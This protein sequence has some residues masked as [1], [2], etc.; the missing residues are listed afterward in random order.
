MSTESAR[1]P[2]R[3]AFLGPRM[4]S[5]ARNRGCPAPP[6]Q[7]EASAVPRAP[8]AARAK[9]GVSD[10]RVELED[11]LAE[12]REVRASAVPGLPA[13]VPEATIDAWSRPTPGA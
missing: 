4:A 13:A 7:P 9:G 6:L 2:R 1:G 3:V 8:N 11:A 10:A 5:K 12:L